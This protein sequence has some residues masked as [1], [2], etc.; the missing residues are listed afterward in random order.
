LRHPFSALRT[1]TFLSVCSIVLKLLAFG[2]KLGKNYDPPKSLSL[3]PSATQRDPLVQS[4]LRCLPPAPG[5]AGPGLRLSRARVQPG[6]SV[7]PLSGTIGTS[8]K[9]LGRLS[10]NENRIARGL[11][12]ST[13]ALTHSGRKGSLRPNSRVPAPDPSPAKICG[14]FRMLHIAPFSTA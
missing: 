13:E 2:L 10:T 14:Q 11:K 7:L 8:L 5:N 6:G 1:C 3:G 4:T 9:A 12:R